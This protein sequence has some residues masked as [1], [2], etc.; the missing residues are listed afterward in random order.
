MT[1]VVFVDDKEFGS[2]GTIHFAKELKILEQYVGI[3]WNG[4]WAWP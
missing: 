1:P 3:R 4:C 2:V